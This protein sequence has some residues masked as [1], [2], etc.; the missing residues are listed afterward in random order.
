MNETLCDAYSGGEWI[1]SRPTLC[2][3]LGVLSEICDV[4][5]TE[6]VVIWDGFR[7]V[8]VWLADGSLLT[9]RREVTP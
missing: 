4:P 7:V 3:L 5:G 6:D 9:V 2:G 1:E 8:A